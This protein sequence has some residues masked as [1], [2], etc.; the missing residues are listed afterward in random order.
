MDCV[1]DGSDSPHPLSSCTGIVQDPSHREVTVDG[2]LSLPDGLCTVHVHNDRERN[3]TR[4]LAIPA[5]WIVYT[6]AVILPTHCHPSVIP[7]KE[8]VAKG[9]KYRFLPLPSFPR[10]WESIASHGSPPAR[11]SQNPE[12]CSGS[13]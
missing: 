2:W 7:V 12:T 6:M 8:D 5:G 4:R 13:V 9:L 10:R 1:H 11:V 3:V